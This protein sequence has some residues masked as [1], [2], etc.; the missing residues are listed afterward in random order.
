MKNYSTTFMSVP[1]LIFT[2][3]C[4][5]SC[6]GKGVSH[7]DDCVSLGELVERDREK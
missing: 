2:I 6:G 1:I 4:L 5:E 7:G 3:F